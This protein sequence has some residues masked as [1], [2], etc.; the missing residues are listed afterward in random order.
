M[1]VDMFLKLDG[2]SGES[3]DSKHKGEIDIESFSFGVSQPGTSSTGGGGGSGKASFS[4]LSIVKKADKSSPNLMLKCATGE[5]IASA[6]LTV[7]KA[8]G[9]QQEYY[10]IKL[11][12]LLVSNFQNTGSGGDSIPIESLSLNFAK[13][14]FEYNEQDSKGGL[15][16]V[17]KSGYDIKG[18]KKV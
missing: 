6:L 10:K 9:S 8:G 14:E 5:H 7:R 13:I 1:A 17:V 11:T 18:N 15:K 2:I 3:A 12:D 4:D 16:G